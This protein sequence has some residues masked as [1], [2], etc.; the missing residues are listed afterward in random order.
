MVR[1]GIVLVLMLLAVLP[2]SAQENEVRLTLERTVCFGACPTYTVTIYE[3]GTVV[4]EGESSVA[5]EGRQTTQIDPEMVETLVEGFEAT[6]YFEWKDEYDA[7]M[8]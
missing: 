7:F 2:S 5:V 4:Y 1:I 3:D 8:V 6:G